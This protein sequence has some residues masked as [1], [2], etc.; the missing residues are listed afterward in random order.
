MIDS[1]TINSMNKTILTTLLSLGVCNIAYSE[2]FNY[3]Y[4]DTSIIRYDLEW[5]TSKAHYD[6]YLVSAS[7]SV[8]DNIHLL[9]DYTNTT[10]DSDPL[11]YDFDLKT[12]GFGANYPLLKY[13]NTDIVV[14]FLHSRWESAVT[15]GASISSRS[16]GK[17]NSIEIGIR[18]QFTDSLEITA[19]LERHDFV[20]DSILYKGF[21]AGAIYKINDNFSLK[22]KGIRVKDSA[23]NTTDWGMSEIGIRYYF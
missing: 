11:D 14:D 6:G 7:K 5:P 10:R 3:D 4:I 12:I 20:G 17:F 2:G 1:G 19:G 21:S 22:L 23:P 13:E 18:N 8:S 15:S 16:S 9:L